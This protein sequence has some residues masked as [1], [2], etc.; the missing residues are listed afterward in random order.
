MLSYNIQGDLSDQ[1]QVNLKLL[2]YVTLGLSLFGGALVVTIAQ[3]QINSQD[4]QAWLCLEAVLGLTFLCR[5]FKREDIAARL[6][7]FGLMAALVVTMLGHPASTVLFFLMLIPIAITG[8]LMDAQAVIQVTV[9]ACILILGVTTAELGLFQALPL[10]ITPMLV[11]VAVGLA[12]YATARNMIETVYWAVDL[13]Q[14]DTQRAEMYYEQK[15]ELSKTLRELTHTKAVLELANVKL[16]QAQREAEQAS[17]AKSVFMSNMSHELRTPLNVVIGYSSSMLDMPQMFENVSL[18]AVY[19]PYVQLIQDNGQYLVGLINDI[20]DLSKI[21]AGKLELHCVAVNLHDILRGVVATSLGL[22]KNK[23]VQLLSDFSDDLPVVWADPKRVRQILLNLLSNAIK[24]THTGSVTL[25]AHVEGNGKQVKIYVIDTGIGIPPEAQATIFDRFQQAQHDTDKHY[26]GT[27]L[28]L[29]ISKQLSLMHGSDLSLY[30]VVGQG[31]TFSFSLQVATPE[32]QREI[33]PLESEGAARL[34]ER[35]EVRDVADVNVVLLVEDD[36]NVRAFLHSTLE[37]AG[38]LVVDT[39]DGAHVHELA[40]GMLPSAIIL[41]THVP[42]V[43]VWE[44]LNDV[45]SD[46]ETRTIPVIV[47]TGDHDSEPVAKD[48]AGST[49]TV[50]RLSKPI[51][52]DALLTAIQDALA[53]AEITATTLNRAE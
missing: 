28:G 19:Q 11:Y 33:Q 21:E 1:K 42:G 39:S 31:S 8:L 52:P 9:L 43:S 10:T 37:S 12:V 41:D 48:G 46:A 27:G 23:A 34:F 14:K 50:H 16:A 26:G 4:L 17:R 2:L 40:A 6:Y 22:L 32:Q 53:S 35:D 15:E 36:D 49:S 18:P 38:Y 29:D 7:V 5:R 3:L 25:S 20:L 45:K 30:S 51:Q 44:L 47:C 13:Q 24:F